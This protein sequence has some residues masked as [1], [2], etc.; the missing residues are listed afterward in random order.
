M[1]NLIYRAESVGPVCRRIAKVDPENFRVVRDDAVNIW[2][3]LSIRWGSK[4]PGLRL[5]ILNSAESV[6]LASDK[7]GSRRVMGD[8]APVTWT[9][10]E[11]IKLPCIIRPRTHHAGK[12]FFVCTTPLE[13][14]RAI[15]R[16]RVGWYA[17]EIIDKARE[18]RVFILQGRVLCVSE[19]FAGPGAGLA[20]NMALGGRLLNVRQND[21]PIPVCQVAIQGAGA[22]GLD[23]AAM[24][25]ALDMQ[26]R[27]WVFEA[28]TAPGLR[29]PHTISC[30]ARGFQWAAVNPP[31]TALNGKEDTW[32]KLIHPALRSR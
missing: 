6:T 24:D 18:F 20:W 17:S 28:N 29:N 2:D 12:R 26:G 11:D 15:R 31:P 10:Q 14:R 1:V 22:L 25:V 19:R 3:G 8:L 16:C 4:L 23:W 30:I 5:P 32:K 21:W 27:A 7:A 13:V 9:V